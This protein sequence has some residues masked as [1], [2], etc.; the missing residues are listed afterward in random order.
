MTYRN[1]D[2]PIEENEMCIICGNFIENCV[3]PVCEVCGV[4]GDPMCINRH[5]PYNKWFPFIW[6]RDTYLDE[7]FDEDYLPNDYMG[8][9]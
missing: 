6:E 1:D 5:M 3:C 9:D 4:Q 7:D 2:P 8:I